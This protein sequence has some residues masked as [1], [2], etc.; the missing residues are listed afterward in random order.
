MASAGSPEA[1]QAV[2]SDFIDKKVVS[3][4]TTMRVS[5]LSAGEVVVRNRYAG[6]NYKDCLA[7][8]GK[9]KIIASFPRIAGIESV[10]EVVES[11]SDKFQPGQEVMVHGFQTGIAFD[12][13]FAE[14]LRVP[15]DHLMPLP[16]GLSPLDAAMIGVPG[17]T[18]AM[19][20]ERFQQLGITPDSGP[21]AV[22]GATGAVGMQALLILSQAGYEVHA[23]SRRPG[24]GSM[25]RALGATEIVDARP[26]AEETR[27]VERPRFAAA[28]DNVSGPVLSWL[29]RS[30]KD[31]GALASV[32]NASGND[33]SC[34]VLPFILRNANL[35]GIVA[36]PA[37]PVRER[38]W[39]RLASDWRPDLS[40]LEPHI[41]MIPLEDLLEHSRK[42]LEGKTQGRTLI[43]FD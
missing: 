25:L 8:Q 14:Y 36:S 40:R 31:N 19:A 38:L 12:G 3:R 28:I 7:I 15:A 10:G 9:A 43:R 37:W 41:H 17:F 34:N 39:K 5:D 1:F 11:A 16:A 20:V 22:S 42:H 23:L 6:V 18:V 29:L 13:G 24:D 35:F 30:L 4:L 27:P 26:L 2:Q 32:G 21:V 33:F